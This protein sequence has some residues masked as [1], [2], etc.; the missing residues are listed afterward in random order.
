MIE[1]ANKHRRPSQFAV[2]D[3]VW[4]KSKEFLPE[5]NISQKLLPAYR[6][7]WQILD[8]VGDVDGP[9]YVVEIPVHLHTYP[10]FHA[11]KLLPCVNND[12]F[13]SWRS[14]IP[15]DMDGKYDVDRIVAEDVYRSG[16]KA[17]GGHVECVRQLLIAAQTGPVAE[18]WGLGRF[19]NVRDSSGCTPLHLAAR[20]GHTATVRILLEYGALVSSSTSVTQGQGSLPL[21]CAARGGSVECVRELLAWGADRHHRD[22]HGYTPYFIALKSGHTACAAL[23]DPSSAEPLVWPSPW[24]FMNRLDSD[25]KELLEASLAEAHAARFARRGFLKGAAS[26]ITIMLP[27]DETAKGPGVDVDLKR[28]DDLDEELLSSGFELTSAFQI[29]AF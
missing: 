9:S 15:P 11:S 29:F 23:L 7:P 24:K 5:E 16:H 2:G 3:L 19:V 13:P 21:H 25:V 28:P 26:R 12:L 27:S 18:S 1:Q 6:G 22:F 17:K 14:M 4:V 8:V 10:V 20:A